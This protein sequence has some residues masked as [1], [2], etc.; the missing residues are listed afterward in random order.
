MKSKMTFS[1]IIRLSLAILVAFAAHFATAKDKTLLTVT[2]PG[3]T[4]V[5]YSLTALEAMEA[6]TLHTHTPW[7]DGQQQFT[8]VRAS[9][10]LSRLDEQGK[11]VRAVALN[12]YESTMDA[13]ELK[14][15]PVIIAY[16]RNGEYMSIRDKGP[17][18]IIFPLDDFPRL[19]SAETDQKMTWQLRRLIVE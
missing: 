9:L 17:L 7:T 13:Q 4:S 2:G 8:G 19:K 3:G 11:S 10:L 6:T 12:D 1:T 15:Y 18:W 16:K 5:E 14:D